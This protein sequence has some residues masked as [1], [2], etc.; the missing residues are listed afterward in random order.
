[1]RRYP[2]PYAPPGAP[3]CSAS[4]AATPSFCPLHPLSVPHASLHPSH[5]SPASIPCNSMLSASPACLVCVP[6]IPSLCCKYPNAPLHPPPAS[7]A[8]FPCTSVPPS[9]PP[10]I[11]TLLPSPQGVPGHR[12]GEWCCVG[13]R[14][15]S[16]PHHP[17][18][19]ALGALGSTLSIPPT[20]GVPR[21]GRGRVQR[22]P[23]HRSQYP[24]GLGGGGDVGV[25]GCVRAGVFGGGL[26]VFWGSGVAL[27]GAQ[28]RRSATAAPP[29]T[30]TTMRMS[31]AGSTC[32]S[33]PCSPARGGAAPGPPWSS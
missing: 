21:G 19:G 9:H 16:I 7:L 23:R 28:R 5:P 24:W 17:K 4:P 8:T 15:F 13:C 10:S 14:P 1:M 12:C 6:S 26:G 20:P 29:A 33:N 31:P 22:A 25:C 11:L 18:L 32:T 27:T 3:L 30:Q 2:P